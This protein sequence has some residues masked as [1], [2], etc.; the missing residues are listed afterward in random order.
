MNSVIILTD[1]LEEVLGYTFKDRELLLQALT[2]K[3]YVNENR[4][5]DGGGDLFDN[6]RLE[7]LGDAV[8][9]LQ[10]SETLYARFP[11]K[12]EGELSRI[13]SQIVNTEALASFSGKLGLGNFLRL[14]RGEGKHGG[15]QR[16][17][18]LADAFEALLAALYLDGAAAVVQDLVKELLNRELAT[19]RIDY[20]SQLQERLQE[21]GG[22][23]P[24]YELV[25]RQGA[26]HQPLFFIEVRNEC[27]S[28]L[29]SGSG[30]SR[31]NAEQRAAG[32][33]LQKL[34]KPGKKY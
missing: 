24:V 28:L 4:H 22:S 7:F 34:Q 17:S 20:K 16:T 18:L 2:H 29:G 12:T 23:L 14:G 13:R 5:K 10:V 8:L 33:A 6:E 11:A 21:E 30:P 1:G 32:D 27:G 19:S 31:K 9:E 3:S 26:D 15:R 25:A